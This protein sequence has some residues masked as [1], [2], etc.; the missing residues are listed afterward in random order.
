VTDDQSRQ[1][2]PKEQYPQPGLPEQEQEHPSLDS[3]MQ[4]D[5]RPLLGLDKPHY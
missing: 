2:D 5:Y 3:E 4:P 1:Q